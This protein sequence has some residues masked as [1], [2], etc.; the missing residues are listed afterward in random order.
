MTDTQIVISIMQNDPR[1]WRHICRNMKYGFFATLKKIF[2]NETFDQE[3]LEDIFQDVCIVLLQ[4]IKNGSYQV[5][6]GSSLYAYL[7]EIGRLT[8]LSFL[9]KNRTRKKENSK[10]TNDHIMPF[11]PQRGDKMQHYDPS[12]DYIP[13]TTEEERQMAQNEFLDRV[14]DSLPDTCKTIFKKFYWEHKTMDEIS[15]IIGYKTADSVKSKKNKCMDK[16]KDFARKLLENDELAEDAVRN[17]AERATLRDILEEERI[18]TKTGATMAAL[19][20]EGESEE[21]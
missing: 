8:T 18:Y 17:A 19:D 11:I 21:D 9:R 2:V 5:R 12:L 7:V 15:E 1:G 20:I 13:L 4:N 6:E 14:F 3:E 16:F 10:E